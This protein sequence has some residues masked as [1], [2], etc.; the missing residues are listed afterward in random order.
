MINMIFYNK[1]QAEEI[2]PCL[3]SVNNQLFFDR[4]RNAELSQLLCI[5]N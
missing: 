3:L 4:Q 2:I 1:K 5:D